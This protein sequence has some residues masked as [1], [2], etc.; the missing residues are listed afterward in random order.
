MSFYAS[1]HCLPRSFR[2]VLSS[3][4]QHDGLAFA[5]VLP[6]KTI[7]QVFAD[8]KV[9]F[10]QD[11]ENIY[12]PALTLW[13]FLSQMLHAKEMRSCTAAVARVIVLLVALG[14][15]PCSD[16]TGAYCR[17]R[18]KLP[19]GIIRRLTSD[20]ADGCEQR[21]ESSWLW[22]SR[23]VHLVDGTTVSMPDTPSNQAAY[24]QASSQKKGVGFPI[25]RLVVL[26]SLATAMVQGMAMGPY[27]GK[28][29]GETALLRELLGRLGRGDIL[30]ADR[31]YC[32]YFMIALL[33]EL[34]IDFVV[35]LHQRRPVDFQRGRRLGA[36]DHVVVWTRP[37]R[38]DWMDET[39]YQ[40]MPASLQVRELQVQVSQPGFRVESLVVVTT[41]IDATTYTQ[42]DIGELYHRRWLV[43]L[44][45]RAIKVTMGMDVLRCQSVAMVHREIW[46]CL[47]AYN[48][49]R[50]TMLEAALQSKRSPREL[51]FTAALQKIAAAWLV[52]AVCAESLRVELATTQLDDMA[53]NIIGERPDRVEPRAVKRRP[54][55]HKLLTEPRAKARAKLL[56]GKVG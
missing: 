30:L 11:D 2:V 36:G 40:R 38:P 33:Q 51:S 29:T 14:K 46:T 39:T 47:L 26:L 19:A 13:A 34:H 6:E 42:E 4:M 44:D 8:A 12:T 10:A 7:Q 52:I 24:P 43:E 48:L 5:Q 21:L 1:H 32:S 20:I 16:N 27:A 23:H 49:I 17:A 53:K 56:G 31:Y 45:I 35:R 3:F 25:A 41:L 55:P 37:P 18:A 50:Q 22:K 9:V 28:E 15:E 54:K